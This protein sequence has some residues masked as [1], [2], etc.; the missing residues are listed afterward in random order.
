MLSGPD[1]A[2][3]TEC[4]RGRG[5]GAV[6]AVRGST[7]AVSGGEGLPARQELLGGPEQ[8][9]QPSVPRNCL[10]TVHRSALCC[11][12][13]GTSGS[14]SDL[15]FAVTGTE[16]SQ[17]QSRQM[18]RPQSQN[19]HSMDA[20]LRHCKISQNIPKN[21]KTRFRLCHCGVLF[22]E[23]SGSLCIF[24]AEMSAGRDQTCQSLSS[25]VSF[26]LGDRKSVV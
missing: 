20:D 11:H 9:N 14:S 5:L 24:F 26:H 19:C 7:T 3:V 2:L 6:A 12:S 16:T 15:G 1:E 10:A 4:S 18:K 21:P 25:V 23:G 8:K 17:R 22:G 13:V